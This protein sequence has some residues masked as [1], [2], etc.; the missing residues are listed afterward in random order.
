MQELPHRCPGRFCTEVQHPSFVAWQLAVSN[1]LPGY[2]KKRRCRYNELTH[3]RQK[4][5]GSLDLAEQVRLPTG[6]SEE[7]W[8]AFNTIELFN[9]LNLL[10]GA[11]ADICTDHTCPLMTAGSYTF[12]WADGVKIKTPQQLSAPKYMEALLVWVE[13]QLAD[14]TF[15]PVQP[16]IPFDPSFKKGIKVIYKRLFRIYAHIFHSHYQAL[17]ECEADAHLNHS[18]KHFIYFAKEFD[19]IAD[20]EL[21]PLKDLV[22]LL[23]RKRREEERSGQSAGYAAS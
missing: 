13:S 8:L 9:E 19:L 15:V 14:E 18:F 23:M 5:L 1:T 16:G 17:T 11:V 7:E 4:T 3:Q 6:C 22:D 10:A 21:L 2:V 20:D 12:A